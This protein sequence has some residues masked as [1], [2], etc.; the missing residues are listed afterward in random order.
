MHIGM[1]GIGLMGHGIAANILKSGRRVSFLDHPG[2]Q[3]FGDLLEL[4]AKR[5]QTIPELV[6]DIDLLL[7]C[8]TGAPQVRAVLIEKGGAIESLTEGQG[9]IDL[10]TSLPETSQDIA[11]A[12]SK[13]GV[14][15]SDAAMTRTPKEAQAGKLNLLVGADAA[16]FAEIKPLLE[17][18][19]ENIIHTGGV[20][21][22]HLMKLIHNF[23]S[24]GFSAVLIEAATYA[25]QADVQRDVLLEVLGKGSGAGVIFERFQPFVQTG[26][27]SAF[28]FSIANATKDLG[29][30]CDVLQNDGGDN[31]QTQYALAKTL[32]ALYLSAVEA[33]YAQK[34]VFEL[35]KFL[36]ETH[37]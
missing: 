11:M 16:L 37:S 9:V 4:G 18:F 21:T 26:D 6:Q 8:V 3:P 19:A 31:N 13:I 12:L 30:Y 7:T 5:V 28:N 1:I 17:V 20:G 27:T 2:N 22:G 15:F 36:E 32:H 29:Y 10:S 35:S 23:V 25:K 34:S 24:L 14:K 33:G